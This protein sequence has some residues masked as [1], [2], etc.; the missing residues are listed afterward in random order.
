MPVLGTKLH[1]PVRRRRLVQRARLIDRL[2]AKGGET[3]RLV[4]VAAPA[5]FGKR[6]LLT[7]WLS[8]AR[9]AERRGGGPALDRGGG[10][11]GL[12]LPS[13]GVA[14]QT[15]SPQGRVWAPG[16]VAR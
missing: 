7:R 8:G 13:P 3:P 11:A 10:D 16:P 14:N 12:F 6:T 2:E 9:T 4:L 1:L 15:G 5:G